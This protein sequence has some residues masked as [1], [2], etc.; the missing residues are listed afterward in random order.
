MYLVDTN[1]ISEARKGSKANVGVVEFFRTKPPGELYLC[2]QTI[3]EI[4]RGVENI[5]G[6]GDQSQ[7][8]RLEV[9]LTLVVEVYADRILDFDVDCAQVWGRL[10]SPGASHPIDKQIAAIALI[11]G[12]EVVTRNTQDFAGTGVK[13]LNPFA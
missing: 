1:V 11:H 2:V 10:M 7:A 8:A 12:L 9:W 13:L 4:R 5:R 6:R 3:G